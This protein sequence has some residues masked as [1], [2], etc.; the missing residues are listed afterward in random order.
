MIGAPCMAAH[1][2]ITK[3]N[4]EYEYYISSFMEYSSV[5][6]L[7]TDRHIPPVKLNKKNTY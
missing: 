6:F 1:Q 3:V 5:K 7:I 2:I 4:T